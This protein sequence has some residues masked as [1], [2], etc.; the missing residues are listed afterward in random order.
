MSIVVTG[1]QSSPTTK[2]SEVLTAGN[3]IQAAVLCMASL[4]TQAWQD[5]IQLFHALFSGFVHPIMHP[6][7]THLCKVWV[8]GQGRAGHGRAGKEGRAG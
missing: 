7:I 2:N 5:N 3:V 4:Q 8:I 6:Q 1:S